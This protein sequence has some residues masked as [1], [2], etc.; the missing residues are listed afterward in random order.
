MEL[1]EELIKYRQ[2]GNQELSGRIKAVKSRLGEKLV[3]LGHHYQ[4]EEVISLS[5]FRGDSFKLSKIASEQ[6]KA[7]YIVFCGVH[8]MAESASILARDEQAVFIPDPRA[9]CPMAD[10]AD[11]SEVE[12]AW[13]EIGEIIDS[14]KIVPIAYVNSDAE[15]KAFCGRNDGACCTSS[16]AEKL[17][18]WAFSRAEKVF[19]FPDEHLGRNSAYKIGLKEDELLIYEPEMELGGIE[20]EK[21]KKAKLI[22]WRGYCHIHTFLQPEHIKKIR[23]EYPRAKVI[24]HPE[25]P[26]EVVELSD[27]SGST[28]QIIKYVESQAQGSIIA[29]GT[30]LH[31]VQRLAREERGKKIIPLARSICPNMSKI[32]LSN[33]FF[34]L[35]K[36]E[37][38]KDNWIN[39]VIAPEP[40]RKD[41]KIALA[42]MLKYG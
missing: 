31:L 13:K 16:N 33:L 34:L 35:E 6:E 17:L 1:T 10:M 5:D 20:P 40:I 36:I 41:A 42:R 8:F 38:G 15:L 14:K 28:E 12:I 27:E 7:R 3:I 2:L 24:V 29:I 9:G 21:L 22:L 37:R 25:C 11:I 23:A 39:Q 30:E 19:F 4:R 18:K 26:R 32:N